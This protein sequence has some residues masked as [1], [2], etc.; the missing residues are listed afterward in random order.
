MSS[1]M[2][3]GLD[4]VTARSKTAETICRTWSAT[5]SSLSTSGHSERESSTDSSVSVVSGE[6]SRRPQF[7]EH[8]RQPSDQPGADGPASSRR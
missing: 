6:V 1:S 5:M 4:I 2:S 8:R 3:S 7:G